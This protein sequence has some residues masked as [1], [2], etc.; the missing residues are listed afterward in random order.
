VENLEAR[1]VLTAPYLPPSHMLVSPDGLLTGPAQGEPLGIALDYLDA[2][3]ADFGLTA[4][5]LADPAVTDQYTDSDTGVTHI[6]LRQRVNGLEVA[7]AD[8]D[9]SLTSTG[10]VIAA[11]GGFVAD[12]ADKVPAVVA[13]PVS[14]VDA[15]KAAAASLGLTPL[16]D[17]Q[18]VSQWSD[19]AQSSV[20]DAPGV[21]LDDIPAR[22]QYVPTEDGAA[23]L[24]WE[25]VI[26]T[27][28]GG[29]WY[30]LSVGAD[31]GSVVAQ[32][33]WVD[34]DTYDVIAPPNESPQDGGF[35]LQ[36]NPADPTAS[37]FGW[38][39]T[40]GI[41]GPEFTD[42]RGNN[43]DAHLDRNAD[44]IPDADE[45]GAPRPNGGPSLDFSGFTPNLTQAPTTQQNQNTSQ[46]NLFYL[47]NLLHD[48]HYKYGF[49]EAAGNFQVNN[50]GRGGLGNDAVQADAQ[51]GSGTNN[52]NFAT[53][54][55]GQAPRMQMYLFTFT[56]P[57]RDAALDDGIVIHE[58]GH[59]VTTR[60]TGGPANSNSLVTVQSGGMGEGWSDFYSLMFL[61]RATDQQNAGY[62]L[63]TYVLGQPQTGVGVR[64]EQYS[65]NMTIDPL[66]YSAYNSDPSKEV[67][68]TGEIWAS[69]LWDLNWLL[70]N[71]YGFDPN[72]ATGWTAA[73]GPG[74]AGN[75]LTLRL[76]MDAL[77]LQPANPS[78]TQARDALIAAD[79][80]LDGGADLF[81]IWS[82][83]ARRGLGVNASTASSSSGSV[84]VDFNLPAGIS[85]FNVT[86]STPTNGA[87]VVGATPSQ[88]VVT[89]NDA[90]NP[91]TVQGSDLLVNGQPASTA[92]L[93]NGNQTITFT[94]ASDPVS[95]Q[96]VESMHINAGAFNR[97][98]D[99]G[100]VSAFDA[101]FRYDATLLQVASTNPPAGG[102]FTLPGPL[103]Y[104]VTFNESVSPGSVQ[105]TDLVLSGAP[106]A[107]VTGVSFLQ[108]NTV[109]RF[110][111]S[112]ITT[113]AVLTASIAAGAITDAF[114]NPGAAF[115][116]SYSVD[117][118]TVPYPTPLV[119]LNPTGS[120]IYDPSV[121][122]SV[123]VPGDT[124]GY[125]VVLDP[126]QTATV[127]VTP[128]APGT[129]VPTVQLSVVGGPVLG[130]AVGATAGQKVVLQTVPV[131]ANAQY[132]I[133]VGGVGASTGGYT[134]Q[135]IL[136]AA[137]ELESGTAGTNNSLGTAEDLSGSFLSLPTLGGAAQRGAVVGQLTTTAT[138]AV[139]LITN[140]D[141]ETGSFAG[142]TVFTA[143]PS[144][145]TWQINNGTLDPNGPATPQPP[146][147]GSFDATTNT[148]GPA[149]KNITQ[150]F[151]VP[152]TVGR[153]TLS[154][155]DR[156]QNFASGFFATT[157]EF[158][159]Q[160][161]DANNT[162]LQTVYKTNP[163]DP[164]IQ[165]GPNSR[166][167]DVTALLQSH[168][169]QTLK[170][171]FEQQDNS[172]F[173]NVTLDN[174]ALSVSASAPVTDSDF[175][176][177]NLTAGQP[178]TAAL[179]LS[180]FTGGP[181]SF[182]G[183]RTD[184]STPGLPGQT[185][186]IPLAVTYRDLNGDGKLDMIAANGGSSGGPNAAGS[187]AVRLG[188]GDG[189]FGPATL[190]ATGGLFTRFLD[191]G[192]V[193]GDGKLDV[194][195]TNTDSNTVSLLLGNGDGTFN[196]ATTYPVH[197]APLGL[198]VRD[199]NGDGLADVIVPHFNTN[200]IGV[201]LG[202]ADGTLGAAQYFNVGAGAPF[203]TAVGD[204]NGDGKLDVVT[205]DFNS[206][207]MSVLLGDGAGNFNLFTVVGQGNNPWGIALADLNGDGKLDV[208]TGNQ[209]SGNI[210]VRL[211]NGNG[212]FGIP[213]FFSTGGNGPRTVSLGDVNGDGKL[214][215]AVP[216]IG[217]TN[218]AVLLGN[219]NGTFGA[220]LLFSTNVNPNYAT[221]ADV[222][223]DGVDD[224]STA[225]A[226]TN[227]LGT[228]SLRL[229][230]TPSV[231]LELQD[232]AGHVVAVGAAGTSNFDRGLSYVPTAGGTYYLRLLGTAN[233]NYQL[234]V[235]R[236]A[237]FEAE[238][239]DTLA[240][241]QDI[242]GTRGV[243]GA[244]ATATDVDWYKVT[245]Q[246]GQHALFLQTATPGDAPGEFVNTL[247]PQLQ[248][249]DA[250]GNL[251]GSGVKLPDGRNESIRLPGLPSGTYF[252]EINS[253][254]GTK[255]EYFL[256]MNA[257][258]APVL[259]VAPA[260][261]GNESIP[262]PLSITAT[263]TNT[264]GPEVLSVTVGGV[265]TDATL[266]AGTDNGDGSW[267]LTPAQLAGLTLTVPD[268]LPG[269]APFTLTVTATATE[270]SSGV[271]NSATRTVAVTVR[272][273]APVLGPLTLTAGD[274]SVP[275]TAID[276]G[277]TVTL[278]GTFT[279][280]GLLD[281]H[282]VVITWGVGEGSTTITTAGPNPACTTLTSLGAGVWGFTATHT[283]LDNTPSGTAFYL[284]VTVTDKDGGTEVVGSSAP[285]ELITN[286][287]FETGDFSGWTVANTGFGAWHINDGTFVPGLGAPQAPIDGS[288]DA[289]FS[290]NGAST[291]LMSQ[292]F[293]V[294][295]RVVSATLSWADR[296]RNFAGDYS[297]PNQQWRVR[298][299]DAAGNVLQEVF[300][301]KPGDPLNQPGPNLRSADLTSLLQGL[302]GQTVR[303]SFEV[304]DNLF[305]LNTYLDDVSLQVVTGPSLTVRNV[306]PTV[307]NVK[308]TSPINENDVATLSGTITDPGTRDSFTLRVFW[309]DGSVDTQALP[310]GATTFSV[311]HRYLDDNPPSDQYAIGM[312]LTDKD[313]GSTIA[314]RVTQEL[315][316][317]G[318]FET[319]DFTGWTVANTG[320]GAWHI[321][322]GTF[323]QGLGGPEA[324]I[325][326][327]FDAVFYE[328]GASTGLVSQPF[329]VPADITTATLSWADRVRNFAGDYSVP[330]QQW[331]VRVLDAA[332]NVLQ[333][334]F[335]TKP[336]DPLDQPGPNLRSADLTS[337]LQGL[338]GQTVRLSF[339]VADNLFFFN[340]SLD[341]V[342]LVVTS[343]GQTAVPP[344][345]VNNVA[346][347]VGAL[348]L[349]SPS[350]NEGDVVT[351]DGSFTDP[352]TLDTH[353]VSISWGEGSANT[354]ISLPAGVLTFSGASHQYLDN[355][356]GNAP[357]AIS[358]T[359]TDKDGGV[360][361][362]ATTSI[363]VNNVA[364]AN[365]N[366]SLSAT[367]INEN[368]SVSLSG[369]FTDPGT[370][371]THTVTIAWGDGSANSTVNLAAGVLSFSGVSHQYL[372]NP[373]G[374]PNGSFPIT[375]NVADKDGGV[376]PAA[377][378][379]VTVNNVSPANVSLALSATSINE[380]DS[381]TLGGGFTDPGTLDTHTVAI[382]WGDGSTNTVVNLAAGVLSFSGVSHQYLNNPAGQPNGSF[383][384][385]VTVTDKDGGVSPTAATSVT[386][387]NVA[388]VIRSLTG[389]SPSPGVRGQTLTFGGTFTDV[390]TL[391]TH[392]ATFD[393]GDGT[394]TTAAAV[395]EA[396]GSG[397]V[398]A[399]HVYTADGYYTVTLTVRDDDAG[400]ATSSKLVTI[401][402]VALQAD[403]LIPGATDLVVGG[404]DATADAIHFDPVDNDGTI[405]VTLNGVVLGNYQPTGRLIA[406]GQG[407]DD[408]I[409]VAGS[410]G[411]Q[412]WLYG[413]AGNDLLKGGGG[414][415]LLMGGAGDDTLI[416]GRGRGVLI[417]GQ[418]ADR[419]VG[420][421]SDD[422]LIGGTTAFDDDPASLFAVLSEWSSA[423]DYATRI[424]NLTGTGTG[425]RL[426]G[427]T[428]LTDL[429]VLDDGVQDTLT[430]SSGL[431]WY[432]ALGQDTI[433]DRKPGEFNRQNP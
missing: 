97:A 91:A 182:S 426:N 211:G 294:P 239:N 332:G 267:T 353:T 54:P 310:A 338:A 405:A 132:L 337:L 66:T 109:V 254:G 255:G 186:T 4:A 178:V 5:D 156:I 81:E 240:T 387:N 293:V 103:T 110:T 229:N 317:N 16:G 67:H 400:T 233:A 135:L 264:G 33:D 47:N 160:I 95:V 29:H 79:N 223:G 391:D 340:V 30:D 290:E 145:G 207:A 119:G 376:S 161:L 352:G 39:D 64:R 288:F 411:L 242:T 301:T 209:G 83:F 3:A 413:G 225:D 330:N 373:A 210:A 276:E 296:V 218:V 19:A 213:T 417:G 258:A 92:V 37:P 425:P 46:V 354:V 343:L 112:G 188:N 402:V 334:V 89:L 403:P 108:G 292:A 102:T 284:S 130:S 114:G 190:Y 270:P 287:N 339:E 367:S 43:V 154:W 90:V 14:A 390:G 309:G 93:S 277:G 299:L 72:L 146:I 249:F 141:F 371:D 38:N 107:A 268:N 60:L 201:L 85:S 278:T 280:P 96:G 139:N 133:T 104:D 234:V 336:G 363:T 148:S 217:S 344:V 134:L 226:G 362:T 247:V 412:A 142:W 250:H 123:G 68:N 265:P 147:S 385:S 297:V 193:N 181:V 272:N 307:S 410:I 199:V 275:V 347:T 430:G 398:S 200:D 381:L 214:D 69:T 406:F 384:I 80:A 327:R 196:A 281:T 279:D 312:T 78:F 356:P 50:Y 266:S 355:Q 244:V 184:F 179:S 382:N 34:H 260:A 326:G 23:T 236:N 259:T 36:T 235:T 421:A 389:P 295:T 369:S 388:P 342:S 164:L 232:A 10:E 41:P 126:Q 246:P 283:Y 185:G 128:T 6:Y 127:V 274:P 26:R 374:Q 320:V 101:T 424:A 271:V 105:T 71:K 167:F 98:S 131:P 361:P 289:V 87:V 399:T 291:G 122:G 197:L 124:D 432:W 206:A 308:V 140:G 252:I 59:G 392:T 409:E 129:L 331:R 7:Y 44:N 222:N 99:N 17:P 113:E 408:D 323:V 158:R 45:G 335:S 420:G 125:T 415:S 61:Q 404:G 40:N 121:T 42:T 422:L 170:L 15:V 11:G 136:N 315:V 151:V 359:V 55:D 219:G 65:Y 18:I 245:L 153:A 431:D 378:T 324:P 228:V 157:Q 144:F 187:I 358:V 73:A 241:A 313:G 74:H 169:G 53:P 100:P 28:D 86:G 159:V 111:V 256:A 150:S 118:G 143:N 357:Y 377:T 248:L 195:A 419:L 230:T 257:P 171:R 395:T 58:Y 238:P 321:N 84:T 318:G 21:S 379:S 300:S 176:A 263:L 269:D 221:L 57:Q 75:K 401:A 194:V 368:D 177:V 282:T 341:D 423:R 51:D 88:Y 322:D 316:T 117:V 180:G 52:S 20:I 429:T 115:S 224:L 106:G 306:A 152:A 203:T 62:G 48:V 414:L 220:P 418:G 346:P 204:V 383:P 212:T 328:N 24:A 345:T 319:G 70:V 56:N 175:Y 22:L 8:L 305:F 428:F 298:V 174:I 329:V 231:R 82:A 285:V 416:G 372:N 155:S 348:V 31:V 25:L 166:S 360:S 77:K 351:L 120:L 273:V 189:T 173:M 433:T 138:P 366:L 192:D 63:G 251:S 149:I 386:V 13:P 302:A 396:G 349:S 333:E 172:F 191:L 237:G 393:W 364:P 208:I 27:P 1:V 183:T 407:G 375:V 311:Q 370:L 304:A 350:I 76:V 286:G 380:N 49:T 32:N 243:L 202:R 215:V 35:T 162:L 168:A 262:I 137:A 205:A 9:V 216:N 394:G 165:L 325:D 12:L 303:L 198:T 116:A 253:R 94:F 365:V 314:G 397:S 227:G 163:G 261:Q 2:H 427:N